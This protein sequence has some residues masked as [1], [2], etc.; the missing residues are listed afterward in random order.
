M[1]ELVEHVLARSI[2]ATHM[3]PL[4]FIA[5]TRVFFPAVIFL[6]ACRLARELDLERP[7]ALLAGF[8]A[9]FAPSLS[10]GGYALRYFRVIS[11]A[12]YILIVMIALVLVQRA[13]R[14]PNWYTACGAGAGVGLV[15]YTPVYYWSLVLLG[16][17]LLALSSPGGARRVL[18]ASGAL[19][20]VLGSPSLLNSARLSADPI[21]RQ[22]LLRV[23][24]MVPGRA[25]EPGVVPRLALGL[26]LIALAWWFRTRHSGWAAF[27]LPFAVSGS[28][29]LIQNLV[30]NRQIQ[31]YHMINCLMPVAALV[32]AGCLQGVRART[33]WIHLGI[34]LV[35]VVGL[36]VQISGYRSW[37]EHARTEPEQYAV[38]TAFS[39]TL[40]W[41]K[42]DTP[43][44]S[45]LVWP[46]KMDATA[47][48]FTS[49]HTYVSR[50]LY[51]YVIPSHELRARSEARK[52]WS[53]GR[54]FPYRA[55][56]V[57]E[58]GARCVQWAPATTA[59]HDVSE[60]ICIFQLHP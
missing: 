4:R 38:N 3:D 40:A 16:L 30:T 49:N 33:G 34:A 50:Y 41:L 22:T 5:I 9:V 26:A 18:L 6:L 2:R 44:G 27:L 42:R 55:D 43:A 47:P 24:V 57:V 28:F 12:A 13:W 54:T 11:P 20:I 25:L 37:V 53:P 59:F 17:G 14:S 31:A 23:W 36:G 56:Y 52:N 7:I 10:L 51:Q 29:M 46:P 35:T 58:Q 48:L 21:V 60:D 32:L 45:V 19:G 8:L 1:P 15:F 39:H